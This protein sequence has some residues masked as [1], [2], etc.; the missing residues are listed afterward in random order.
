MAESFLDQF[1]GADYSI[2]GM[3]ETHL[4]GAQLASAITKQR[5]WGRRSFGAAAKP[6]QDSSGNHGGV[7]LAASVE[8][9]LAPA[10]QSAKWQGHDWVAR[11][12]RAKGMVY[13]VAFIYM[14]CNIGMVG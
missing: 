3:A 4:E 10:T 1:R 11:P 14:T 7:L 12:V 2:I 6:S 9:A 13:I 8:L 5:S